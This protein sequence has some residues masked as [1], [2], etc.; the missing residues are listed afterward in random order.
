MKQIIL[1]LGFDVTHNKNSTILVTGTC[2][3]MPYA[4]PCA[5]AQLPA[6]ENA[7]NE[8]QPYYHQDTPRLGAI[9]TV[10]GV[11]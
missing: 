6:N 3:P 4:M 8:N 9:K 7:K 1:N 11:C 5:N 10:I 2:R